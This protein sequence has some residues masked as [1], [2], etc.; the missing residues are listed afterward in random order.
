[1]LE[2]GHNYDMSQFS[3]YLHKGKREEKAQWYQKMDK[4]FLQGGNKK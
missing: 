3:R 4:G 1:M 2:T